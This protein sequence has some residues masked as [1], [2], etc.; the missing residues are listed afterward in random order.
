[1]RGFGEEHMKRTRSRLTAFA[2]AL[3]LVACGGS[4]SAEEE[5][6]KTQAALLEVREAVADAR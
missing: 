4:D 3:T 1:M 2:A 6:A 5:L